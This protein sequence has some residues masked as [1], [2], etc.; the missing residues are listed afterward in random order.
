MGRT[1]TGLQTEDIMITNIAVLLALLA[2]S[3]N[4]NSYKTK[5]ECEEVTNKHGTR[6]IC[7]RVLV[8]EEKKDQKDKK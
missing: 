2:T 7:K 4:V 6:E 8:K 1:H 3:T 5:K